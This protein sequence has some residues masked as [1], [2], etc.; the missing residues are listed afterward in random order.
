MKRVTDPEL[1]AQLEGGAA[2]EGLKPVTDPALIAQLEADEKRSLPAQVVRAVG[3]TARAGVQGITALPNMIGDALGLQSSQAVRNALSKLGLPE[4]ENPT[5]RIAEDVASGMAGAGGMVGLGRGMAKAATPLVQRIGQLLSTA[6]GLQVTAGA[7]GPGAAS[8][9]REEGGGPGAQMAAGV[10]GAALP[11][12]PALAA[13]AT[14]AA[15]RGG[16]A[17][18]QRVAQN[19]K[20]F[21]EA[22][23]GTPTVGQAT[24]S[25]ANRAV[26]S[27]L[28][29]TPGAAGRMASKAQAESLALGG[30]VE[31][32]ARSLA[33]RTGAAPAGRAIKGGLEHF[34][35]DFKAA[36]GRLYD[37]LDNH[38]PGTTQVQATNTLAKLKQ[39]TAPIKGA[40]RTSALIKTPRIGD[41]AEALSADAAAQ[42]A[43]VIPG[44]PVGAKGP[45]GVPLP[46]SLLGPDGNPLPTIIPGK[47]GGIPYEA[48]KQLRSAVGEKIAN[49]SLTDDISTAQWKQLYGALSRDMAEAARGA[50]PKAEAAFVRANNFHR[51]G[52]QRIEDVLQPIVAKGDP[53]DI[54]QAAISG[55]KEG[56][57]TISGVMKSLQ[58]ESRKVVAATMLRRLGVATPGKQNELGEV[59]SSETFLTN[60]NRISPDSKRV[61]FSSLPEQMRLD[62]DKIAKVAAN[63][64]E[65]SQVFANPSGTAPA[66]A[67]YMTAGG[68][69]ISL[70]TGQVGTAA[71]IAGGVGAAN[72]G[73]RVMTS[74]KVVRWLAESTRKPVEQLPAQLNQLFQQSLYMNGDERKEVRQF[75]KDVRAAI[76]RAGAQTP[77]GAAALQ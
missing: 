65:G 63:I 38:I 46:P 25:R 2:P 60:W 52:M 24:E 66:A 53:E 19:I 68:F 4:A 3:R 50:G 67:G 51:A 6:P 72:L 37:A 42:P 59:F 20:T 75:V 26:E 73:A 41:V 14:R 35:D 16:E 33:G 11:A 71:S 1:L 44:T 36:S 45:H 18:R 55:T 76:P 77:E 43:K 58:P 9:V 17:G 62:L 57:T 15:M 49:P 70:L 23:A 61:L 21:E 69:V 54:F 34:V 47:N 31:D 29:K 22:G 8:V 28:A 7:T 32:M 48:L 40:E 74:P 5:E 39:L 56:A 13:A 27:V 30:K 10:A 64:R 12:V